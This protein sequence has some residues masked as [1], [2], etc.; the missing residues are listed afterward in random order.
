M[1]QRV[2]ADGAVGL[3]VASTTTLFACGCAIASATADGSSGELAARTCRGVPSM[4]TT[5]ASIAFAFAML[6]SCAAAAAPVFI[7]LDGE[8]DLFQQGFE[9]LQFGGSS[10]FEAGM[11]TVD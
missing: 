3:V 8:D 4:T 2:V 11:L 6:S 10:T 9:H 1:A 7:P 5:P